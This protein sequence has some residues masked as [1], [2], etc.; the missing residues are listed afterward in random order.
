MEYI[1]SFNLYKLI[2]DLPSKVHMVF[3]VV[4]IFRKRKAN[5]KKNWRL[6]GLKEWGS[7]QVNHGK[8][9]QNIGKTC[10][11]RGS[12]SATT[13]RTGW[14]LCSMWFGIVHWPCISG[15]IWYSSC[16]QVASLSSMEISSTGW[17]WTSLKKWGILHTSGGILYGQPCWLLWNC[18]N[19]HLFYANFIRPA[20]PWLVVLHLM[21]C[22][23]HART[24]SSLFAL[25]E[26]HAE[27]SSVL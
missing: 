2:K 18:C 12:L 9:Q 19:C 20:R 5:G 15:T 8:S 3:W 23:K 25:D 22:V 16:S 7:L 27:L 21:Q 24:S 10:R 11:G 13:I 1:T 17:S 14:R 6:L 4:F 26:V